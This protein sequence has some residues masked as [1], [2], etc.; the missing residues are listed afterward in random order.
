M[1]LSYSYFCQS[2]CKKLGISDRHSPAFQASPTDSQL[3]KQVVSCA[4]KSS[5]SRFNPL[6]RSQ[7]S[8]VNGFLKMESSVSQYA[9]ACE[10]IGASKGSTN[11]LSNISFLPSEG[12]RLSYG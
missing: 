4:S 9:F 8:P 5:Q 11:R 2:I 3:C 12:A 1:F 10:F 7:S 6:L